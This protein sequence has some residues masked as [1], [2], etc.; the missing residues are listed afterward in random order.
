V[1]KYLYYLDEE[2]VAASALGALCRMDLAGEYLDKIKLF[3][4][5]AYWDE[6][7][8]VSMK[9]ISEAGEYLRDHY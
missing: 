9:A 7:E 2:F 3:I 4:R 5:G 1:E 8:E 6:T